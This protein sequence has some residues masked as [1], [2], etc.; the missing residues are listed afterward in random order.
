MAPTKPVAFVPLVLRIRRALPLVAW[1]ADEDPPTASASVPKE[2]KNIAV[3]EPTKAATETS[4]SLSKPARRPAVKPKTMVKKAVETEMALLDG[5]VWVVGDELDGL[6]DA[7]PH[8]VKLSPFWIARREVTLELWDRVVNW[9]HEH[10]YVDLPP[11]AAK[12]LDHPVYAV[13]W[14]EAVMWCNAR[15]EMEGLTPC[16]YEDAQQKKVFRTGILNLSNRCVN[17]EA[18]GYRLPTEA[19]WEVAARGRLKGKRFP[20]GDEITHE[21]ANYSS[22]A[23]GPFDKSKDRG[24]PPAFL[25]S[26]PHT[27]P[28]GSFRPNRFGLYDMSGNVSEWCWDVY[29]RSYGIPKLASGGAKPPT[30]SDPRGPVSGI[31]RVVRGGSWRHDA[32]DARCASR[33]DLPAM[34]PFPH[35][36]F[37]VVR[38]R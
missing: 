34:T 33:F 30:V 32:G 22:R 26:L 1:T 14:L 8:P 24:P 27:A 35:V 10:G 18:K 3:K 11:G 29:D 20:W 13:S 36:G 21:N 19:E 7:V 6:K 16:Y 37:R 5:G 15:S 2:S 9:A 28:T 38:R 17:W 12:A 23:A 31:S 25:G 4:A